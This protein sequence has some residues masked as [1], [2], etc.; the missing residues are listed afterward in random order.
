MSSYNV[1]SDLH[2]NAKFVTESIE[3]AANELVKVKE[4][5]VSYSKRWFSQELYDLRNKKIKQEEELSSLITHNVGMNIKRLE[6][7]IIEYV[8]MLKMKT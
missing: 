6:T 5:N 8:K 2:E 4:I 3:K 1:T 7:D